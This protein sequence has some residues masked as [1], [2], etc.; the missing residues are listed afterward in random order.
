MGDGIAPI[1]AIVTVSTATPVPITV[2]ATVMLADGFNDT[3]IIDKQLQSYFTEIAY[4][5]NVVSYMSIGA[6]ILKTEG[7]EFVNNL[8]LNGGTSDI[9]LGDEEI[10]T[11]GATTWE[12]TT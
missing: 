4:K 1:G 2:K 6:E 9:V 10:P 5:K 7:V 12:V 11:L 3:S 8:T